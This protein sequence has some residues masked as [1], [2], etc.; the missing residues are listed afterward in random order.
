MNEPMQDDQS[1]FFR[2]LKQ[3]FV[4]EKGKVEQQLT[5]IE[6]L[7][8]ADLDEVTDIRRELNNHFSGMLAIMQAMQRKTRMLLLLPSDMILN[9]L[10]RAPEEQEAAHV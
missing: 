8:D 5:R 7:H 4:E 2:T 6:Q 3:C 9:G 10:C 1:V